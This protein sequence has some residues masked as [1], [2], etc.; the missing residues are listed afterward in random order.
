MKIDRESENMAWRFYFS[1]GWDHF[2]I[3][4]VI[5]GVDIEFHVQNVRNILYGE[6]S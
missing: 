1:I 5:A 2:F 4:V 3:A 6:A